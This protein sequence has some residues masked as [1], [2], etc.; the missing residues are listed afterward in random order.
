MEDLSRRYFVFDLEILEYC[1]LDI[2]SVKEEK[3]SIKV[4]I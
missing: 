2:V 1:C 3:V 4:V